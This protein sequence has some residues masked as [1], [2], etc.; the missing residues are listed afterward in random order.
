MKAP[1]IAPSFELLF[2]A[3]WLVIPALLATRLSR[4]R[5]VLLG[6][7]TFW[8]FSLAHPVIAPEH[9][10]VGGTGSLLLGWLW[11]FFYCAICYRVGQSLRQSDRLKQQTSRRASLIESNNA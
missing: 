1:T 10:F 9:Y 2:V 5:G 4:R 8:A 11:G 3:C 6:A 7:L